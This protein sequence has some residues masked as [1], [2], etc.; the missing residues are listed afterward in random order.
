[1]GRENGKKIKVYGL[2]LGLKEEEGK[3]K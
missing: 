1:M 2:G 3:I